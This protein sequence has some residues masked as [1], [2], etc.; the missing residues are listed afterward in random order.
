[1]TITEYTLIY[2]MPAKAVITLIVVLNM[3]VIGKKKLKI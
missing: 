2:S 1:M 3:L